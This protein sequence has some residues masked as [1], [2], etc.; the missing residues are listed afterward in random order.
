MLLMFNF[1][2]NI[3]KNDKGMVARIARGID[4]IQP[5]P[6]NSITFMKSVTRLPKVVNVGLYVNP[7]S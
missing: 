1:N 6:I 5:S 4:Q 3:M 7:A 2:L